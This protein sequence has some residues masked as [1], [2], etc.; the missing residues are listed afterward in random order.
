[1]PGGKPYSGSGQWEWQGLLHAKPAGRGEGPHYRD[2][3]D[4]GPG[5]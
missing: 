2:R 1:M 4:G 5:G 3:H